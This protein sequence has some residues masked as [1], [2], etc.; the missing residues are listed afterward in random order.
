MFS[1][2]PLTADK[3]EQK[4]TYMHLHVLGCEVKHT[5]SGGLL[6]LVE[7]TR[8]PVD[9]ILYLM[10]KSFHFL[11]RVNL[12]AKIWEIFLSLGENLNQRGSASAAGGFSISPVGQ[13]RSANFRNLAS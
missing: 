11:A 3:M 1:I 8:W 7:S 5:S 9:E 10:G 6:F 2:G 4:L 13:S 12:H